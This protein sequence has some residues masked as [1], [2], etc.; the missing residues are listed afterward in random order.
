MNWTVWLVHGILYSD[1]GLQTFG[2]SWPL[3]AISL[4]RTRDL[5]SQ[6]DKLFPAFI[7]S[8][9]IALSFLISQS[10][11][12]R[13]QRFVYS[14]TEES[15]I[16]VFMENSSGCHYFWSIKLPQC[17]GRAVMM[18]VFNPSTDAEAGV[19]CEFAA[20][21]VYGASSQTGSKA[22]QTLSW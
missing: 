14:T 7:H 21:L 9:G 13:S 20:S 1:K 11:S 3:N 18:H 5:A 4:F 19:P 15:K 10:T 16:S 12:M 17:E 2:W 22:A 8:L 6:G